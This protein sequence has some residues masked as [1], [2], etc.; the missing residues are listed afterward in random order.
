VPRPK[1]FSDAQR[2][3]VNDLKRQI[4]RLHTKFV[5]PGRRDEMAPKKLRSKKEQTGREPRKTRTTRKRI[6]EKNTHAKAPR[7]EELKSSIVALLLRLG[8]FA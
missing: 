8:A 6:V 3:I 1:Q 2:Q 4:K 5:T 7:R